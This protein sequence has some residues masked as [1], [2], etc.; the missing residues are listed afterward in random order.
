MT[1]VAPPP[2]TPATPLA[3]TKRSVRPSRRQFLIGTGAVAGLAIGYAVW[4][5]TVPLNWSA[6]PDET[7]VNGFVKIG[8]DGRVVVAIPQAEMGQGVGSALAQIVADELGADWNTVAIEPAPLNPIYANRGMVLDATAALPPSFQGFARWGLGGVI[9]HYDMQMTG[10]STSVRGFAAPMR[11]AGAAAREALCRAAA[12]DWGVDA[13]QCDTANG[14]VVYKAKAV[15]FADIAGKVVA[16]DAPDTPVLRTTP[17]LMGQPLPRIDLPSKTDGSAR[18]GIDV[19]VPGLVYAAIKSGP[20]GDARLLHADDTAARTMPGVLDIVHGPTWVAVVGTTWWNASKALDAITPVFSAQDHPAG[21][22]LSDAP[23]RMLGTNDAKAVRN[24]GDAVTALASGHVVSADYSVPYLAHAALEPMNATAHVENGKVTVWAPTQSLTM[25]TWAAAKVAGVTESAVTVHPTLIG[26]S[27]GRK[28]ENDAVV[29]AVLIAKAVKRPVQLIWS[30]AEDLAHDRFRPAAAARMRGSIS[31]GRIAAWDSRIAV[32]D[33]ASSFAARNLP[34]LGGAPKASAEGVD[35][36][37]QMPYDMA[38]VRVEHAVVLT[39]VPLGFWRSVGHSFSAFFVE[40]FVDELAHAA[41]ADPGAFRLAMLHDKPR[42]AAVLNA[43]LAA[44]GPLGSAGSG[45]GRGVALHES[46]GSI[47]AQVAE[48][49]CADGEPPRVRRVYAAIDC[50]RVVNPDGLRAQMEGGINYGLAAAL[51][52]RIT[53]ADGR[54]E[55]TNFDSYPVLM[56]AEAPMIHVIIVPSD[57]PLGGVG[58]PGTPPIA[59]AVA[60][61]IFAASGQ[62]LRSLPF[63]A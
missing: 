45:I 61:A 26:G 4:P 17:T 24:D 10:G 30:R 44:A 6:A 42:H 20:A 19:R 15:R 23:R 1:A 33:V 52:G 12:R 50:G 8:T 43:V 32:P 34:A 59:P 25:T 28:A 35:G 5:R 27:F 13:A 48:V 51:K 18:F 47:V 22:G 49:E 39:P 21:P 31:N 55:Q 7:V 14:F 38:H 57:A 16:A 53:F 58:E 37:T 54:V 36:A 3:P 11:L 9:G 46:F 40:S 60:N 62:R 2:A 56:L 63:T 41:G 29:Q